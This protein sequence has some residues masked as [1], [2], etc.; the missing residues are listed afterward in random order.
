MY[1][2]PF[3]PR[4]RARHF[5]PYFALYL[6]CV[7]YLRRYHPQNSVPDVIDPEM[8]FEKSS[9]GFFVY[10]ASIVPCIFSRVSTH[11]LFL[12]ASFSSKLSFAT[13][14]SVWKLKG[15]R[16]GL[17]EQQIQNQYHCMNS[18]VSVRLIWFV[19]SSV[20]SR[21]SIGKPNQSNRNI[22]VHT[23]ILILNLLLPKPLHK[24][25]THYY[26]SQIS[27]ENQ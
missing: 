5:F 10:G 25:Q 23:V 11:S 6:E 22:T 18:N 17:G 4:Q 9:N 13:C 20:N 16:N 21:F 19:D 26:S 7:L 3:L 27:F 8:K 1:F 12:F 2:L 24:Q 15:I 14:A